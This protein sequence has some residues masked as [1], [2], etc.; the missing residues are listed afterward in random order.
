MAISA[1]TWGVSNGQWAAPAMGNLAA[2]AM[3]NKQLAAPA[4]IGCACNGQWAIGNWLR[5]Q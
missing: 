3:G 5:Q 1:V 4:A 2:P